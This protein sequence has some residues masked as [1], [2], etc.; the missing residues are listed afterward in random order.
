MITNRVSD[1][2]LHEAGEQS[3]LRSYLRGIWDRYRNLEHFTTTEIQ[4]LQ[5]QS[6]CCQAVSQAIV[7]TFQV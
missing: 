5:N 2:L 3:Y 1:G 6:M 4:G 7:C